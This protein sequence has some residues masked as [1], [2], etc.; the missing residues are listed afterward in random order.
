MVMTTTTCPANPKARLFRSLTAFV[1]LVITFSVILWGCTDSAASSAKVFRYNERDG[2]STLDPARIGSRA[3]WWVGDQIYCGL[4]GLDSALNPVPMI[5][6]AWDVSPD[7]LT[8]TFTLRRDAYFGDDPCFA[9]G[10]G[11]AVTVEDVR[12]SFRRIC[13]RRTASTGFW[14]FDGKVKGA[15]EF[16][17]D[18]AGSL[19]DVEGFQ[20]VNDTT[21]R[22]VLVKPFAPFLAMLSI[23]YCYVV[24]R[25]AVEKYGKDFFRHPVGAGPFSLA[26]WQPDQRM[27]L[28]RNPR[29]FVRDAQGVQL[30]YLD[31]VEVSFMK[32]AKT[33]FVDFR[34]GRLDAVTSIPTEFS[35]V[36]FGPDGRTAN[37]AYKTFGIHF[38]PA[39]SVSYLGIM[40]DTATAGGRGSVLA[41]NV[42]LRRALNYAIDRQKLVRYVL[43]GKAIAAANGPVPPGAA[44]F[45]GVQGYTFSREQALKELDSA[46]YPN[47]KGLPA[48][49]L[50]LS[51]DERTFSVAEAV[52][53]QLKSV[54]I[55]VE[56]KQVHFSQ[57]REMYKQG[58]LPFWQT[59]WIGDYPD[60]ENFIALFYSPY[61]LRQGPNITHFTSSVVDSVYRAALNPRLSLAQRQALY[62]RAERVILD[63][64][65]WV[66][67]HY[68]IIQRITQPG[69]QGYAVDPLDRLTLACVRKTEKK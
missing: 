16:Y 39:M 5:A 30:P 56:L 20:V 28:V 35:D 36:V 1:L 25:E 47:G 59:S 31:S 46:G 44:G 3:P 57:H 4:I 60:A 19:T 7:G 41:T 27:V 65:P 43:K 29:Y 40:M 8:W 18:S 37:D 34:D 14:V 63:Q 49:T 69:V 68:G 58:K 15:T 21:F 23:P 33:E 11:R 55:T 38:K 17:N 9:N 32:D 12:Y 53:D 24:P 2:V 45:S 52:Q 48:I 22:I 6:K 66:W 42:H 13:D 50:Q 64:A 10:K 61:S 51:Q 54:G 26:A 67:L 62:N